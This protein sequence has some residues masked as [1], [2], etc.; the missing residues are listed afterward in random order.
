[1]SIPGRANRLL[2]WVVTGA[3]VGFPSAAGRFRRCP[4]TVTG[5]PVRPDFV[6]RDAR[7]SRAALGLDPSR[8]VVLVMG[9][10]QGAT[11]VN[12]CVINLLPCLGVLA[13]EWQWIHL[14]GSNDFES[15]KKAYEACGAQ[16]LVRA[17]AGEMEV[18]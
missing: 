2:S 10:S 13:T 17:F 3:F 11:G 7:A 18:L 16:A 8:P 1:N 9:G 6:P 14:A 5:T 12:Q 15:V 4:V